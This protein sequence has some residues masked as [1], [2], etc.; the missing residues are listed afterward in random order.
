MSSPCESF[1]DFGFT[2]SFFALQGTGVG[3]GVGVGVPGVGVAV[4]VGVG[5][6]VPGVGVAV[7]VGVGG[8]PVSD[9]N[10]YLRFLLVSS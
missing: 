5:V 6:G 10:A 2:L 3:D 1:R 4:D 7:G 9:L 8:T